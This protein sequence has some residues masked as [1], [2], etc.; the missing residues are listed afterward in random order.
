[1]QVRHSRLAAVDSPAAEADTRLDRAIVDC[2]NPVEDRVT[3]DCHIPIRAA[4]AS[5]H[6]LALAHTRLMGDSSP[7]VGDTPLLV[8]WRELRAWHARGLAAL[9]DAA[10]PA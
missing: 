8:A 4:A 9:R 2:R 6:T 3:G 1:N 10:H 5:A 7:G